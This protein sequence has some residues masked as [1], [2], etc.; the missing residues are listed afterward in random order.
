MELTHLLSIILM[1]LLA[2]GRSRSNSLLR[3]FAIAL[4]L[5]A[6]VTARAQIPGHWELA[7]RAPHWKLTGMQFGDAEHG[8]ILMDS[9][10]NWT[11]S[12]VTANG[13]MNWK[14]IPIN[15]FQTQQNFDPI[16]FHTFD[17]P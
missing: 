11:A 14:L 1:A 13:G 16:S 17:M 9:S 5:G 15:V 4:V 3:V 10:W 12:L 2:Q 8:V 7:F 6:T